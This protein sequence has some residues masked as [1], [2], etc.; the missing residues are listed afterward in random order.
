[1]GQYL[2]RGSLTWFVARGGVPEV[3]LS[4]GVANAGA[5]GR[6]GQHVLRPANLQT[7]AIHEFLRYVRKAGFEGVPEPVGIDPD[8][9]ERLVLIE[10]DVPCPPFP[11]WS[12]TDEALASTARLLARFHEAAAGF[13]WPPGT[14]WND[15]LADPAGGSLVCHN[16]VC[17]ENVVY[18]DGRAVALLDFD[19]VAPG[20]P[21]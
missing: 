18:R 2:F 11:A 17:P 19:F 9:R 14:S 13:V 12:Q 16:D 20:R 3:P 6:S 8:G 21:T 15:E 1:M 4:G 10:G 5:V 7:E